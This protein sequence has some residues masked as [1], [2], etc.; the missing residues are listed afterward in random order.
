MHTAI[1]II[2]GVLMIGGAVIVLNSAVAMLRT[3]D[4][5]TRLSVLTPATGVGLPLVVLGTAIEQTYQ[6][7]FTWGTWGKVVIII[8]AMVLVSSVGSNVLGRAVY[9]SGAPL[10]K[11]TVFND[12]AE[13]PGQRT[14][15][16][17]LTKRDYE[18]G[19][20]GAEPHPVAG[21]QNLGPD[22]PP[23]KRR[24]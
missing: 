2:V 5:Y 23:A 1:L 15:A 9:L 22:H 8:S 14:G 7:G 17:G 4:A 12:L 24:S 19:P 11:R 3:D 18:L 16:D 21:D 6:V 10:S 20:Y 13:E